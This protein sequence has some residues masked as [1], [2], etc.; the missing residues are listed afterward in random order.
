[1]RAYPVTVETVQTDD[2]GATA[3]TA[4]NTE[5]GAGLEKGPYV[6]ETYAVSLE[7]RAEKQVIVVEI[8]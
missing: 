3:A 7:K 1:V 8:P 6:A 2:E 5:G 4:A